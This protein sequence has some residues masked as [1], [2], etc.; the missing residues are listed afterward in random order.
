MATQQSVVDFIVEQASGAG[1]VTGRKMFGEYALFCAGKLVA[2]VCDDQLFV[3]PTGAGR[4]HLVHPTE[5]PPYKGAKPCF[6]IPGDRWDDAAWLSR[7]I[8]L[9]ADEL[10]APVKKPP[11]KRSTPNTRP[12]P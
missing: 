5:A 8:R 2:L 11:R 12:R 6:L 4:A 3:K 7:L 10:P 9:T 1:L